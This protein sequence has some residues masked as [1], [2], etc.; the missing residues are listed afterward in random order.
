MLLAHDFRA[1]E[2]LF[3]TWAFQCAISLFGELIALHGSRVDDLP[4]PLVSR[5]IFTKQQMTSP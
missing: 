3:Y 2:S 1:W 5:N 4:P